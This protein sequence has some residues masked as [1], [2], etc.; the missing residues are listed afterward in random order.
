M[1]RRSMVWSALRQARRLNLAAQGKPM[2]AQLRAGFTRRRVLAALAAGAALPA[3]A[4]ERLCLSGRS[5]VAVIGGGLSGLVALRDLVKA[6]LEATLFEARSRLGGRILTINAGPLRADQGGQF[7]NSD[8]EDMLALAREYG[9]RLIDRAG[10]EGRDVIGDAGR[11]IPPE[12]LAV[13]LQP[14][15]AIIAA[16][17]AALDRDY[18]GVAPR[19]DSMSVRDY[20]D[21]HARALGLPY[22]RRLL[23]ASIRTEYGQEP[24]EASALELIFNLPVADGRDYEVLGA[25]DERFVLEGGS[26]ALIEAMARDLRPHLRTGLELSAIAEAG[27]ALRLR[28][29]GGEE[30]EA[31]HVIIT[32]PAPVLRKIDFGNLLPEAWRLFVAEIGCGRN[33]KLNATYASRVWEDGMGRSGA[34]WLLDGA[35]SE[36]WDATTLESNM[37]MLTWF[38][39][40]GQCA[41][42]DRTELAGL[43][44]AFEADAAIAI[45]GLGAEATGWQRRTN[46]FGDRYAKGS[47]SCFRPGQLT[48]FAGLFWIEV[49]GKA[50]QSAVAGRLVFAGEHLSDEWFGFMNGAAQ[51]GRLAARAVLERLRK[52]ITP[53]DRA[54]LEAAVA[55]AKAR[56]QTRI[57]T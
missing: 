52:G 28:F 12:E 10:F 21:R 26:G 43:R 50:S 27:D 45:K 51:T 14:I 41:Q 30:I 19:I 6:G 9:L 31:D 40:A 29:A 16:D 23:E 25:S 38:L 54:R 2:P 55:E 47:Y 7:I 37:G 49:E 24:E 57:N 46:W 42:L 36:V 8:H 39:G 15:A 18:E 32:L 56:L 33:E 1:G 53:E 44:K 48:R 5:R 35:F 22:V 4:C 34:L 3:V 11:V 20:L 13:A 17:A